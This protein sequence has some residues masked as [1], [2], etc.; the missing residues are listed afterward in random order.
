VDL[1]LIFRRRGRTLTSRCRPG[2]EARFPHPVAALE[3]RPRPAR[4]CLVP[5]AV[6]ITFSDADVADS[7]PWAAVLPRL[8]AVTGGRTILAYNAEFDAGIIAG[9]TDRDGLDSGH[10]DDE[11]RWA[12][13]MGRR[14]DWQLRRRWLPPTRLT[15]AATAKP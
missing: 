5:R 10:L 9:H 15:A 3:G 13:L 11:G 4:R 8:L 6:G 12:C 1:Y 14:S 7:P 2:R